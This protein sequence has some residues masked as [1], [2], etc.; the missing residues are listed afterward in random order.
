MNLAAISLLVAC[1]VGSFGR[2]FG[3]SSPETDFGLPTYNTIVHVSTDNGN[4]KGRLIGVTDS[5]ITILRLREKDRFDI[6]ASI[7]GTI[8][9]KKRFFRSVLLDFSIGALLT[10]VIVFAYYWDHGFWTPDDPPFG[11]SLLTGMALGGGSGIL[12]GMVE[13]TFFK[14]RLPVNKSLY[15]FQNH[16]RQLMK[17]CGD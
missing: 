16:R 7:I 1:A 9:V 6:P 10:G 2:S 15:L 3:Q 5:S 14:I 8:K 4:I 11:K 12:Y 13:S 17:Y